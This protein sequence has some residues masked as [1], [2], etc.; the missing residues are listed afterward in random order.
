VLFGP[1]T[2]NGFAELAEYDEDKNNWIDEND[3]IYCF[4]NF[5]LLTPLFSPPT[6]SAKAFALCPQK[7]LL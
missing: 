3:S 4:K 6:L 5:T 7:P 1:Q 2:G